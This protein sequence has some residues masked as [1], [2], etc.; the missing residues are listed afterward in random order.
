MAAWSATSHGTNLWV[1][2]GRIF[3]SLQKIKQA[4]ERVSHALHHQ[5]Q[6]W[7]LP[8]RDNAT[9]VLSFYISCGLYPTP[10][11]RRSG[12]LY[13]DIPS[14]STLVRRTNFSE[15]DISRP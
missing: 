3:G 15:C 14:E 8:E 4:C 6:K 1:G 11:W 9:V 5:T 7:A 2:S 10:T 13:S 12:G